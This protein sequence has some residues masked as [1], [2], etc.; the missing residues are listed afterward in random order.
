MKNLTKLT[1]LLLPLTAF[2]QQGFNQADMQKMMAQAVEMQKCMANIDQ[3]TLEAFSKKAEQI[4]QEIQALCRAGKE[5]AARQ[6][7]LKFSQES[8]ANKEL[9]KVRKCGMMIP[10]LAQAIPTIEEISNHPICGKD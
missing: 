4:G 7:L 8:L 1:L 6:Q 5:N 10:G 2:A 3:T 9:A